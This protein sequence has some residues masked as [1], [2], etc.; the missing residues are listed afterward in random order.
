MKTIDDVK[1]VDIMPDSLTCDENVNACA[2]AI[3][4]QLREIAANVDVA[5]L[6]PRIDVLP[7]LVL[8]HIA[9][10][11]D[12]SVW[13]DSWPV[14]LKRSVLKSALAEKR[15]R[16]TRGA[17]LKAIKSL[18]GAGSIV[19]WWEET[20]KGIPYTFKIY[21]ALS[22][23]E[24]VVDTEMQEDLIRQIDDAKSF[25]SHYDLI[26]TTVLNGGIGAYGCMRT[27]T[28]AAIS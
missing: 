25:R 14:S 23:I 18:G 11:Y 26:L 19:E 9:T 17:V 20:P 16:G 22:K 1:L 12:I 8:D 5:L 7:S 2:E 6:I 15:K 24:G 3:D 4:P 27:L 28:Y 13:R 10:Q 21:V